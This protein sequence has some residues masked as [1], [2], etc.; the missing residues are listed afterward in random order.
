MKISRE[1][2]RENKK[3]IIN[4]AV[5]LIS[6]KGY[7]STTMR[8]IA[9]QV[10][11]GEA[12]IYNYFPAKEA[13]LYAYYEDHMIFCIKKLQEIDDFHT[14]SLQEQL[15][16]LFNTSLVFYLMDREFVS[17]TFKIVLFGTSRNW[18]KIKPIRETFL[19]AV[20]D[21]MEAAAEAGEIP[22]QVF[23]GLISQFFMDAYIGVIHYWINDTS[24]QF[25]N[26][27]VLIDK[28]LDIACAMLKAGIANKAFDITT[29]LFKTHI[30]SRLDCFVDSFA[31]AK[32]VKRG[33]M[34]AMNES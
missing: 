34:E 13:I 32:K 21:M 7:K 19:A 29:F 9:K 10:G 31:S 18:S 17:Q 33:F 4:S 1:Q 22:E 2:K 14:Y 23:Q 3:K 15:Q 26:T 11:M 24:E 30:L 6:E 27:S 5:E 16:V 20:Q 8:S 12:T 25:T 28:G